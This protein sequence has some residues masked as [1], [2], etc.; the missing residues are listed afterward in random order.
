MKPETVFY[1]HPYTQ[2]ENLG[3]L[4]LSE[5]LLAQLRGHGKLRVLRS[6]IPIDFWSCLGV[7]KEEVFEGTKLSFFL[8]MVF[9]SLRRRENVVLVTKPGDVIALV[10]QILPPRREIKALSFFGLRLIGVKICAIGISTRTDNF[11]RNFL[12]RFAANQFFGRVVRD[13]ASYQAAERFRGKLFLGSDLAFLRIPQAAGTPTS[14]SLCRVAVSFRDPND[15]KAEKDILK[16]LRSLLQS[17]QIKLFPI[18][19]VDRDADF[20]R[21]LAAQLDLESPVKVHGGPEAYQSMNGAISNRLHVLLFAFL[22]GAAPLALVTEANQ[23]ILGLFKDLDMT[24]RVFEVGSS[25][26]QDDFLNFDHDKGI[27][28]IHSA[29]QKLLDAID[30]MVDA[31]KR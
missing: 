3:D 30:E 11:Q 31:L 19:Q 28:A 4:V 1:Y 27:C 24:E 10:S 5:R 13:S 2:F 6:G 8:T 23:K 12:D 20:M 29:Q 15:P 17:Q 26:T 16:S 22:A 7:E 14:D 25:L 9:N 21:W 18:Y